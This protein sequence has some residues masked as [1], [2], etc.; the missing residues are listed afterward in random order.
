MRCKRANVAR[1]RA[2][3]AVVDLIA[4][5]SFR[6]LALASARTRTLPCDE[7]VLMRWRTMG[8]LEDVVQ[9]PLAS[10]EMLPIQPESP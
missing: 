9:R 6:S 3:L 2:R 8:V 4:V 5:R 7:R 1:E 10:G